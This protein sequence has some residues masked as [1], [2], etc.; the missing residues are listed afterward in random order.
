MRLATFNI[1]SGRPQDEDRTEPS[2][3][4]SA[5]K[6]LDA[7]VLGLQEV[8][9]GQERSGGVDQAELAARAMQADHWRF[10][11]ALVGTPGAWSRPAGPADEEVDGRGGHAPAM[12]GVALLSR[13]PVL[14]WHVLPL[15]QVPFRAPVPVRDAHGRRKLIWTTDEPR[16]AIAAVLETPNG[17]MTVANTHL[18]FIPAWNA[19][20]LTRLARWM[21]GFPSPH[22][23][24]G[25]L[26]MPGR[27]PSALSPQWRSL[28]SAPT[29]PAGRPHVQ[30]DHVLARGSVRVMEAASR[31]LPL[32][33][34][35]ALTADVRVDRE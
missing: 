28:V 8:D 33:D 32:S 27:I 34:H 29:W 10:V 22:V 25:D 7:D 35:R 11:P 19:G 14:A 2:L 13:L 1:F 20:Q 6:E 18:S 16:T 5:V 24:M 26:N 31:L 21:R 17:Q 4:E 23:L 9:R 30:L 3:L 12:Y 15:R